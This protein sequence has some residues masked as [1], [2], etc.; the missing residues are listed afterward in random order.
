[1]VSSDS[2][3]R[4]KANTLATTIYIAGPQVEEGEFVTS[5]IPTTTNVATRAADV[6]TQAENEIGM[7]PELTNPTSFT[8]A[9]IATFVNFNGFIEVVQPDVFRVDHDPV[10][11][12]P[13]GLL[14]EDARTNLLLQ[15]VNLTDATY[16]NIFQSTV[17]LSPQP[18]ISPGPLKVPL[19]ITYF[20]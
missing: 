14:L 12:A 19:E 13:K 10:T 3:P 16:W 5:Y 8:R 7:D 6:F 20:T 2:A 11:L 9:S 17:T 15:S 4:S 1:M 18:D